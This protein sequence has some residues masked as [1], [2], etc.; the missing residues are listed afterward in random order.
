MKLIREF[1]DFKDLDVLKEDIEVDGKKDKIVRLKGTFLEADIKNKNGRT[2]SRDLLSREVKR[3][4]E[5][6]ISKGRSIAELDHPDNPT[7]N[8]E[9]VSHVIE[10]LKME[11]NKGVGVAR[12]IDTP[13]GRIAKTL[14]NEGIILGMSTRG[15]G[16]L[17]ESGLVK[18]DFNL[19]CVDIVADP[20]CQ[21]A[22]VEGILENKEYIMDGDAIVEV[23][24][25]NLKKK[26]DKKYS[27]KSMS[28][29]VLTY[30]L[31]FIDE[32]NHK[33]S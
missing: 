19:I 28:E 21:N 13:M 6:K 1:V 26:V 33:N 27:P 22:Y 25:N 23:A 12:I 4:N 14:V 29:H 11:E 32:I 16:S 9:R 7:V 10:S 31:D 8:L 24:V 18:E 17:D 15:V 20:S 3:Y 5:E 30:M 2:Y